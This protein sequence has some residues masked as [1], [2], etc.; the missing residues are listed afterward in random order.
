MRAREHASRA[1][2]LALPFALWGCGWISAGAPEYAR[3]RETR[4]AP[5]LEGRLAAAEGYLDAYPDGAYAEEV[6]AYITR[7]EPLFFK[8]RQTSL[9]GL[10]TYEKTLPKGAHAAEVRS[11]IIALEEQASRP[12]TLLVAAASTERRLA[13]AARSREKARSE[14]AF[15]ADAL[16]NP[17][18]YAAPLA[19]GPAELVTAFAL[20][21]PAPSCQPTDVGRICDKEV[22]L[23]FSVPTKAGLKVH[24]LAFTVTLL[25]DPS[26]R[27]TSA[28]IEGPLM[29]ARLEETFAL[30]PI[31][32]DGVRDQLAAVERGVE[33]VA[34]AFEARVS[35]DPVCRKDAVA[36]VVLTLACAG[37]RVTAESGAWPGERDRISFEPIAR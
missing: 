15:W 14:L 9:A 18:A 11:R 23:D 25:E 37:M 6:R 2:L 32:E 27:P 22:Q 12:D 13:E 36:P 34:T 29:F 16:S 3:Y 28:R 24:K 19:E 5:T 7:A 30:R 26:G 10:Q 17:E 21:L 4:A 1:L 8:S 31:D 33:L 35:P 20:S